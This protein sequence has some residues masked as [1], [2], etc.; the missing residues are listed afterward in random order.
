MLF[1]FIFVFSPSD[2]FRATNRPSSVMGMHFFSPAHMMP[3][4]ECV[5]GEDSSPLTIAAVMGVSKRLKK[6]RGI[7]E[8]IGCWCVL[9]GRKRQSYFQPRARE[10]SDIV[11]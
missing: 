3:L 7:R 4:V 8:V 5:R 6:V 1:L 11:S 9:P 10:C 2:C